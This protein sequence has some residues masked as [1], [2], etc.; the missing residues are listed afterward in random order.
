MRRKDGSTFPAELRGKPCAIRAGSRASSRCADISAR[1]RNE[2]QIRRLAHHDSLTELPNRSL[3]LD[4]LGLA[5]AQARRDG[6]PMAILQLDLDHFKD[7]NDTLGHRGRRRP[8]ARLRAP[9]AEHRARH[10]HGR[11]HRRRRVRDHP[12][13]ARAADRRR[14]RRAADHRAPARADRLPGPRGAHRH[15]HRHH[16]LPGRRHR[17]RPAAQERRHRALPAPRRTGATPTASSSRR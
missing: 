2:D 6:R 7:V 8:A 11:A 12:D 16:D 3:F 10:R 17:S 4:R 9:P 14:P 13:R 5:M 1:K 15:Q